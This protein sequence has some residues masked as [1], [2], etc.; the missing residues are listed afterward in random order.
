MIPTP[1]SGC[2]AALHEVQQPT[3]IILSVLALCLYQSSCKQNAALLFSCKAHKA[4]RVL[5]QVLVIV[6]LV[7]S[8]AVSVGLVPLSVALMRYLQIAV[9]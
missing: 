8:L 7:P 3:C 9:V 2:A 4:L 6:I 5:P 1:S